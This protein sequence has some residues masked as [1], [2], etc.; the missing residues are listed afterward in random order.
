MVSSPD[1]NDFNDYFT[2]MILVVDRISNNRA[3]TNFTVKDELSTRENLSRN[4][5]MEIS[6]SSVQ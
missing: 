5:K 2:S 4:K 3:F 1:F 6:V